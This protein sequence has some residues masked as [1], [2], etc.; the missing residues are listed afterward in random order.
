MTAKEALQAAL[1]KATVSVPANELYELLG[2]IEEL[3]REVERLQ[4]AKASQTVSDQNA[5]VAEVV[6]KLVAHFE[7]KRLN[8]RVPS[9]PPADLDYERVPV[10]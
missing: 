10:D 6:E 3:E 7:N 1:A 9:A 2:R 8:L 5:I 4:M